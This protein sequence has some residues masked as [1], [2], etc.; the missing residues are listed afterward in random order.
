MYRYTRHHIAYERGDEKNQLVCD[1]EYIFTCTYYG[2]KRERKK[3][4]NESDKES[5][6]KEGGRESNI[7]AHTFIGSMGIY[8]S[9][10]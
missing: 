5:R 2:R 1:H 4:R 7:T 9:G 3:S 10:Y 8:W 6:S